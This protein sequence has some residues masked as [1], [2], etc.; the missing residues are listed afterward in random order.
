MTKQIKKGNIE[1]VILDF[2]DYSCLNGRKKT[3]Q[4]VYRLIFIVT[5]KKKKIG[6][7]IV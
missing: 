7:K 5:K 6:N 2:S 4:L 3:L 1:T